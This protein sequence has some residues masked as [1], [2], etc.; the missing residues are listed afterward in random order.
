MTAPPG[1]PSLVL[2][3]E[4]K[5]RD[6]LGSEVD[7]R[8]EASGV[9]AHAG[10]FYV[11]FDNLPDIGRIE[12][13]LTPGVG[14]CALIRQ[15]PGPLGY[16]DIAYDAHSRRFFVLIESVRTPSGEYMAKVQEFDEDF[17]LRASRWLDFAFDRPNKGLE[18]LTCL[19]RAGRSYLLGM[20][21][22]NDC[23]GGKAG[24]RPGGGRIQVFAEDGDRWSRVAT[25]RLPGTLWFADYSSLSVHDRRMAVVSQESSAMWVGM[26]EPSTWDICG[27]GSVYRFPRDHRGRIAYGNVEGVSWTGPDEVVVVSDKAK[28]GHRRSRQ[29]DQS[30]HVFTLPAA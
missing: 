15:P 11:I 2:L 1:L 21:E 13:A 30:I 28:P 7:S 17:Q 26:L 14:K 6:L 16:E 20:C 29:K 27:T 18:G 5:I 4:A 19:R 25:I 12:P 3:R 10:A 24:E 9:L 23:Q 8:F 22:G